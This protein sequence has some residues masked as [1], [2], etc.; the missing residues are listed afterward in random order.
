MLLLLGALFAGMLTVLA[1]CVLPLLPV[2]IGGSVT[3]DTRSY[4][5]PFI[6]AASL[7]VSLILFTLLLKATSLLINIPP[8]SIT[9]ISGAI[10][11]IIG[12]LTLYPDLYERI[13][14][15][16]GIQPRS[17]QLLGVGLTQRNQYIGPIITG[18]ALGPVFS[19]CSP[20]YAYVLATILPTNF[21]EAMVYI[22]AYVLGLSAAL[23]VIGVLGQRFV[24]RLSWAS[25]PK[26]TF[27]RVV[28]ILF[29]VVGLMVFTGYDKKFQTFVSERTP[30]D[31][32]GLSAKLIPA[33]G[34]EQ[35]GEA[36]NVEPYDAPEFTGIEKWINSE[37][38]SL[39]EDLKG[40]VVLVDFWTYSCINCIRTQPYLRGW[41]DLYKDS[42]LTIVGVHA[43]EFAFEKVPANVEKAAREA[44]LTYPIALDNSFA[45]WNAYENQYWPA[46][47]LIDAEGQVRRVHSGEGEYKETEDAIRQLLADAGKTV[48][49][50][51][52]VKGDAKPPV[53]NQQTPETYLGT[54]RLGNYVG[55]TPLT[56]GSRTYTAGSLKKDQWT[57]SGD[58]TIGSENIT[59]GA[60]AELSIRF[61]AKS[62]YLVTGVSEGQTLTLSLDGSSIATGVQGRDVTNSTVMV[63]EARLYDLIK[64]AS[65]TEGTITIR[66]PAGVQLHAF[67]F[68]S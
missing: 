46:H 20:V 35:S 11:I 48:P 2:I 55:P 25:N 38:L 33:R 44:K 31:F 50:E 1:P 17:Q 40:K 18:A 51:R 34:A 41:N 28:A 26:G 14:I 47:Y 12:I 59:A 24:R 13:I 23:L 68:G 62:V 49:S 54:K 56:Q 8:A 16:L 32:D 3:G 39:K 27:Q 6:I 60:N 15:K 29:I 36:L 45:T 10:I 63:R 21:A 19:S 61:A 4:R 30:F 43:P 5:R 9:L 42:G 37:Q 58:W 65:F 67:T 66:V 64:A 57:L 7:A 53:T 52:F 22:V